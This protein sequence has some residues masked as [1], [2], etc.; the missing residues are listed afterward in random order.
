MGS[1]V[2]DAGECLVPSCPPSTTHL[3]LLHVIFSDEFVICFGTI[4]FYYLV[5]GFF[6]LNVSTFCLTPTSL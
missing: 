2:M 4:F 5:C 6:K 3:N 1:N